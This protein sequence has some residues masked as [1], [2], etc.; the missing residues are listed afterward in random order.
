[1]NTQIFKSKLLPSGHLY[2]PKEFI[3]KNV[4]FKVT[5]IFEDLDVEASKDD[6]ELSNITDISHDVFSNEEINYY[7]NLEE[8]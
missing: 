8:I 2:C 4:H 7:L 3:K 5:V 6:I 1:M